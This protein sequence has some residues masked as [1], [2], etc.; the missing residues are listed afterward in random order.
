VFVLLAVAL[1]HAQSAEPASLPF[2]GCYEVTSLTW[3]PADDIRLIPQRIALL[4]TP[5]WGHG[6]AMRSFDAE[7]QHWENLWAWRPKGTNKVQLVWSTGLGGFRGTLK[8]SKDGDLAGKIKEWCD[9]RCG[10]KKRTGQLHLKKIS[11]RPD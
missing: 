8:R 3:T 4:N 10:W 2:A 11:C 1:A 5:T 9:S 7:K 6:F